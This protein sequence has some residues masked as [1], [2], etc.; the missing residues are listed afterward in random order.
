M[1]VNFHYIQLISFI[2]E[3]ILYWDICQLSKTKAS[4]FFS[5]EIYKICRTWVGS[6]GV[7]WAILTELVCLIADLCTH[8]GTDYNISGVKW[9]SLSVTLGMSYKVAFI[10]AHREKLSTSFCGWSQFLGW[11]QGLHL[12]VY[13]SNIP[14]DSEV[15]LMC[16]CFIVKMCF[17]WTLLSL[18]PAGKWLR[19]KAEIICSITL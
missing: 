2:L 4:N 11:Q 17:F 6:S 13:M 5:W 16:H 18:E 1:N 3:L 15:V 12:S 7:S 8:N 10:S 14:M 9:G 19:T